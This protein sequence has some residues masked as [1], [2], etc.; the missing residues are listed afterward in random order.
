[1][2][3]A[4]FLS[5]LPANAPAGAQG[6]ERPGVRDWPMFRGG[7]QLA[8]VAYGKLPE[9]LRVRWKFATQEPITSSAAIAGGRVHVGG[10]DGYL[11]ALDLASG[12]LVWKYHAKEMIRSSPTVVDDLVIFGDDIGIMHAVAAK[13]GELRWKFEAED[14]IISSANHEGDRIVFGSYDGNV[15]C[16]SVRN[17]RLLWKFETEGRVHGTPGISEGHVVVAG[18]DEYLHV[19]GLVDGKGIAKVSMASVSG[20]SAAIRGSRAFVGTYGSHVL[21]IDWRASKVAWRFKDPE[22]EFPYMSSAAVTESAVVVG[23][24]D[25]RLRALDPETGSVLWTFVTKG[26]VESSPVVVGD[27]VF[28][29]SLDGILYAVD[30]A[31][32]KERW[33]FE[34]GAP[35]S[36]SP[37]VARESLVISDE[38][39]VVYC[40]GAE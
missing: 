28:F 4:L 37:A 2:L 22:R 1:M 13:T 14:Q 18:C 15:Y 5:A 8:G 27:R 34:T 36:A 17:G 10:D 33:R 30:I 38:D 19:I 23:G 29:G 9:K 11:Y 6:S 20:A 32:G 21:G 40:F 7:P 24:R 35:I 31:T 3:L 39:G 16:L 26:R 25:K 12:R